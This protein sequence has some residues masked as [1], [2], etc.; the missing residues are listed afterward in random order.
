MYI[1]ETNVHN[2]DAPSVVVPILIDLIKPA[3]IL[4]VGCGIGTWLSVFNKEGVK[5]YFGIDGDYVNKEML[6]GFID[7]DHFAPVDL[8]GPFDLKRKFDLLICLEVAEHLPPETAE[9]FIKSLVIHADRIVFSAAVPGQGGQD[10]LNEQW[11]EYW[12][13]LFARH[14]Y[15]C[16]DIIRPLIW[17]K[18][19][20]NWWYQQNMFVF[21]K[22]PPADAVRSANYISFIHPRHFNQKADR[23]TEMDM[24]LR[25]RSAELEKWEN[26]KQGVRKH[27][28]SFLRSIKR[29]YFVF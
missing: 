21:S 15:L 12:V 23:I 18:P 28:R 25:Q 7:P 20:V 29:K 24:Q 4:D 19:E 9:Q 6:S 8:S 16:Y 17:D 5:D 13:T 26:G 3:S 22:T 27:W 10:H 1:H 2:L 11:P 14:N